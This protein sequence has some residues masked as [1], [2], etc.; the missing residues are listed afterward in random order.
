MRAMLTVERNVSK[1][2]QMTVRIIESKVFSGEVQ[3]LEGGRLAAAKRGFSTRRLELEKAKGLVSG[4]YSPQSGDLVLAQVVHVGQH[5]RIE[6]PD[7]RRAHLFAGD[8]ILVSYGNRY[9]PDQFEA[10]VPKDLSEC[11][12][13][14]AGGIASQ[15]ISQHRNMSPVTRIRPQ[16][17]LADQQGRPLN[18]QDFAAQPKRIKGALPRVIAVLGT[19]MNAGKT[20]AL[21]R[22]VLGLTRAGL[23]AAA[24]KV[25]GTGAGG[26]YWMMTDAGA[27]HVSD[28]TDMGYAST[29]GLEP[30]EVEQIMHGL[31]AEA[32]SCRPDVILLEIADGLFQPETRHLMESQRFGEMVDG[33]IFAANDA[34]GAVAGTQMLRA[35][36]LSV[37]A[38]TGSFTAAPLAV[39]ETLMR[40]EEPVLLKTELSDPKIA[41]G[42]AGLV[43]VEDRA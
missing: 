38:V 39:A 17:V 40:V 36:D 24:C 12:L 18:L 23:A 3:L 9:A 27:I 14:A 7:G 25:T 21:S 4:V 5:K 35:S 16:G 13:V 41:R 32:A 1:G 15:V 29:N 28:F 22:L 20:T 43:A 42:L 19:S 8:E 37:E 34:M 6:Q 33:V 31:V 10:V 2:W 30:L 11:D 26:D